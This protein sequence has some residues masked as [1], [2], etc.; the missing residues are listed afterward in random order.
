MQ[1]YPQ[2]QYA[3]RNGTLI[4]Y[5]VFGSGKVDLIVCMGLTSNCDHLGDMPESDKAIRQLAKH[6]RVVLFDRRGSGHSD[7][8][9]GDSLPTWE[10]WADDMLAVL[11]A[12]GSRRAVVFGERDGGVMALI[13]A[14]AHPER[15][16]ALALANTTARTLVAE[17]Y[18]I[19]LPA[20][21]LDKFVQ[22][23][24]EKWGTDDMTRLI[25]PNI[26]DPHSIRMRS[27]H[28]RGA[29][30]PTK[31]ARHFRYLFDFD[32]RSFLDS[33]HVP[34]IIFQRESYIFAPLTHGEYM[35]DHILDARLVRLPGGN[36]SVLF[37]DDAAD[38]I[39]ELVEFITGSPVKTSSSRSLVTILFCDMVGSTVKASELGDERWS[40]LLDQFRTIVRRV[41]KDY[42]GREVHNAGDGFFFAFDRPTKAIGCAR[43]IRDA[44]GELNV[45]VRSGLHTG[46]C[47]VAGDDLEGLSV[48]IGARIAA[49][50]SAGEIWVSDTVKALTLGSGIQYV[51]RGKHELKGVPNSWVL[52]AV[53]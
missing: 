47:I 35:A 26:T 38:R 9:P 23:V 14:S 27:R 15:T 43:A 36:G 41:V 4:A 20:A 13:F 34:T 39:H 16:L 21:Q 51:E 46:E 28:F 7:S 24:R 32:A 22:L 29:A 18:P 5:Q 48:H 2:T 50:A 17:D 37:N 49:H 19:G 42:E 12:I 25:L 10:D 44:I 40:H 30:T 1:E 11:D 3:D 6:F 8:L 33:V 53:A 52:Y 45:Q 31:A